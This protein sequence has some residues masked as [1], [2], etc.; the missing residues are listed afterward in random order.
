[1]RRGR[2]AETYSTYIS[3]YIILAGLLFR[4]ERDPQDLT[5]Q[6]RLPELH[7]SIL[8][9]IKLASVVHVVD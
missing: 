8:I 5:S 6:S 4:L 2:G 1:M 7:F 3:R 9:L